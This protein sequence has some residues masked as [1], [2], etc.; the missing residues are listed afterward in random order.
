MAVALA[1]RSIETAL[2]EAIGQRRRAGLM[3]AAGGLCLLVICFVSLAIGAYW[4]PLP[5]VLAALTAP[6]TGGGAASVHTTVVWDIRMVRVLLSAAVG[7]ALAVSGAAFQ[8]TFRNPLVEPYVLGVSSGAA[9]GA[10]IAVMVVV[11]FSTQALAFAGGIAAVSLTFLVSRIRGE[12]STLVLVLSGIVVG[13]FFMAMFSLFQYAGSDAQL[14]RLVFWVM[15]GFYAAKW[16]QVALV[17][18]LTVVGVVLLGILGW[19]LNIL[20]L[21]DEEC[22]ALGVSPKP[23]RIAI[24]AIA[25]AL[26]AVAVSVSGIIA[27]VG[28]LIPHAARFVVG[29]DNRTLIPFSALVG[30]AFLVACDDLARTLHSGELPIGIITSAVGAPLL[31]VLLRRRSTHWGNA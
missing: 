9:F 8:A 2:G 5:D 21:G 16:E 15:G 7:A 14:R 26:T 4:I 3:V 28:L 27:W 23:L 30:A 19:R 31:I 13:S 22:R 10:G 17:V 24:V 18:P 11:P 1:E 29:S 12:R 20:T 25:T 6:V